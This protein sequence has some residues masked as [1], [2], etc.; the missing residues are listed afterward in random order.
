M[1]ANK[2]AENGSTSRILLAED[3]P[4][5]QYVF[6]AI[7]NAAGFAVEI[8]ENGLVALERARQLHPR[9]ILLDMMM[10][11]MDG[12]EAASRLSADPEFDDVPIVAL[13]AKAMKGDLEKTLAA[14]CDDYVAK[15][16]SR[17]ALLDKIGQWLNPANDEWKQNRIERRRSKAA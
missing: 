11:V 6:R 14:G 13:T 5:N 1:E 3:D 10:P 16:V 17:Q 7:L 9:L 15:P 2:T 4:T 8:V 12:Y